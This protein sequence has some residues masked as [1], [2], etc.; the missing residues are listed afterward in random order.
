M[1]DGKWWKS[2]AHEDAEE[3]LFPNDWLAEVGP[4]GS[5]YSWA[6]FDADANHLVIGY[7]NTRRD[8]KRDALA[9]FDRRSGSDGEQP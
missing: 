5:R 8:A 6:L 7:S 4:D 1:N 3:F 9:E 2:D